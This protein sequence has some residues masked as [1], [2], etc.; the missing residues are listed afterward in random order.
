MKFKK[1]IIT[2]EL[3]RIPAHIC[4]D[5]SVYVIRRKRCPSDLKRRSWNNPYRNEYTIEYY[6]NDLKLLLEFVNDMKIAFDRNKKT[7]KNKLQYKNVK[8]I[9]EK[10][11]LFNKNSYNWYIPNFIMNSNEE[12]FCSWIRAF[13]DDES[14]IHPLRKRIVVK[15]MNKQG[16]LQINILLTKLEIRSSVTGPNCDNSYYL[17]VHKD[18]LLIYRS[19]IGFTM[20]R[21]KILLDTIL[22]K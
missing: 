20:L 21:K 8:H 6:N 2:P 5:G 13:F 15:S 9:I 3:A 19:K 16:L 11:E 10:L 1:L 7:V 14:Y 18:G 22:K 4:A 12:V 17:T